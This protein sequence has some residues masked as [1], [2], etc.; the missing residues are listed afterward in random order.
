M[1]EPRSRDPGEPPESAEPR[2]EALLDRAA[3][4]LDDA[5]LVA[6]TDALS[7][8]SRSLPEEVAN[9]PILGRALWLAALVSLGQG[10]LEEFAATSDD[11]IVALDAA[12]DAGG[13]AE[14][15]AARREI[16]ERL[17]RTLDV[18]ARGA[19]GFLSAV[20][21]HVAHLVEVAA[22][23]ADW[24]S[25][26]RDR[27]QLD[28]LVQT[29]ADT[30]GRALPLA[31]LA[32][33]LELDPLEVTAV[34]VLVGLANQPE[35]AAELHRLR[36]EPVSRLGFRVRDV[37]ELALQREDARA[38]LV[39]RFAGHGRLV[40]YR[41]VN[42]VAD[43]PPD[44]RRVAVGSDLLWFLRDLPLVD[45]PRPPGLD[46]WV[47]AAGDVTLMLAL[48][49]ARALLE[50][51]LGADRA[52]VIALVGSRG[53]GKATV[54]LAAA[55]AAGR[56]LLVADPER[57]GSD[58][59]A[60]AVSIGVRDAILHGAGLLVRLDRGPAPIAAALDEPRV[61]LLLAIDPADA[62]DAL[63]EL[64]RRRADVV[65][66]EVPSLPLADQAE[67]WAQ[68]AALL[69][70]AALDP[71]DVDAHL[72]RPGLLAGDVADALVAA[73][74]ATATGVA[75]NVRGVASQLDDRLA[76]ELAVVAELVPPAA[77]AP[78][79]PSVAAQ[80][81][82]GV[83]RGARGRGRGRQL[84]GGRAAEPAAGAHRAGRGRR[85]GGTRARRRPCACRGA[86]GAAG[87]R[88][89][90]RAAG[91][92]GRAR[93]RV[94]RARRSRGRD[95]LGRSRR[96]RGRAGGAGGGGGDDLRAVDL[97]GVA[98]AR[99]RAAARAGRR[100]AGADRRAEGGD[101]TR[102]HLAHGVTGIFL[103]AFAF[104]AVMVLALGVL[105]CIGAGRVAAVQGGGT[106]TYYAM[107]AVISVVGLFMLRITVRNWGAVAA[108][109]VAD[110]GSWTLRSRFG[111]VLGVVPADEGRLFE[112]RGRTLFILAAAVP[113]RQP[114]VE[115]RLA[116]RSG[117]G[118]R[119]AVSGPHTYDQALADLGYEDR[120]PRPG[121][122]AT[123]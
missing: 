85:G 104:M 70:I 19:I 112:L 50:A 33:G 54:T 122:S 94:G 89:C 76:R 99:S 28:Q 38:S 15:R 116:L 37:A 59:A 118:Y 64:R 14:A 102:A 51:A 123:L 87:P 45:L 2:V 58:G 30:S 81:E 83:Q 46:A 26:D 53:A 24:A 86:R 90:S 63:L 17:A 111:R 67:A 61:R 47:A 65:V 35:L 108:I 78:L 121:E 117:G 82:R 73:V 55:A 8:L 62:D 12:G 49:P 119:L 106:G 13:A 6:A 68:G 114:I 3:R 91:R 77:E 5:D 74:A 79:P 34:V 22:G 71:G 110:D 109:D 40:R 57:A 32:A 20:D 92:G 25:V 21:A 42:V 100:R 23:R 120:A 36:G 66:V 72:V 52:P 18:R 27:A 29:P 43:G 75:A 10:Q 113:K 7:E 41:L 4:A 39:D 98:V 88:R 95:G 103:I 107:G 48:R 31:R 115:G 1:G 105:L 9:G 69:S 93:R 84:G 16:L 56:P 11:A 60:E 101:M 97:A 44:Q 80:V 96:R